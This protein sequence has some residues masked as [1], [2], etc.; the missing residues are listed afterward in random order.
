MVARLRALGLPGVTARTFHAHAL[1]MLRHFWPSRHDGQPLPELLDSKLPILG[2]LARQLPGHYRFTPSKDLA[3]EIEWAKARRIAPRAYEAAGR[4]RR[5]RAAHPGRPVR[6]HVRGLRAGEG[7]G[8]P[9]RLRRPARGDRSTCSR[10]TPR[11]RRRSAPRKRWFSVDEY[12]DTNPLQ[13]RLLE[14]WLGDS[15]RPVRRGRRGPDDLHVHGGHVHVPHRVRGALAGRARGRARPQLPLDAAGAG[16]R[17][18]AARRARAARSASRRPAA[19]V[20]SP[21]SASIRRRT[22]SSAALVAAIR[23]RLA[24][25]IAPAEVAV[26]VR[27]NAQLAPIEEALT[28]RR[29]RVRRPRPAVLRPARGP[30]RA[31]ER[32]RRQPALDA[33]GRPAA[34][35][36]P[37]ALDRR[38][39][40]RGDGRG[41]RGRRGAGAPGAL[42]HAAR[43][44]RGARPRRTAR[45]ERR[46]R[47]RGPRDAAP[48]TS[49]AGVGG[50]RQPAHVPPREGA[51][52][53][54]GVPAGPR[55]RRRCRSARR[56]TT[57]TRSPRSGGSCTWA[58]RGRARTS[59]CRG[60]SDARHAGREIAPPAEPLPAG[61]PAAA[62]AGHAGSGSC[63]GRR[64]RARR[65]SRAPGGDTTTRCSP[66]S[67]SG[68]PGSPGTRRCRPTSS[69][70]T[71]RWRRSPRPGRGRSRRC[72]G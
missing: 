17:Q 28:R 53:G 9:D 69:P 57:T 71:R 2:R 7:A 31:V 72:G 3:D 33:H 1:S 24:E 23:A 11:P 46:G 35:R 51:R 8:R 27:M 44:R 55:G 58:S 4:G 50:R 47:P 67:A 66:P 43:D 12:Q 16:A 30:R 14:L 61:P 49:E 39:G 60:R 40:L 65:P 21:R 20:P 10:R 22:R 26:L 18:P 41:R 70:T 34:R 5:P 15:P 42:E 6:A 56:S 19:T 36:D 63:P 38:R 32:L 29:H 64:S 59:R 52:V 54:R 62:R 68:G 37:R 25:G 45:V 48:R 13:Q